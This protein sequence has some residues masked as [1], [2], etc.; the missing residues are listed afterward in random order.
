LLDTLKGVF[1]H[2]GQAIRGGQYTAP[3]TILGFFGAGYL[4]FCSLCLGSIIAL[5][6]TGTLIWLIP[7]IF[8]A[9][10]LGTIGLF[11]SVLRSAEKDPT[12][13]V[14]R[15]MSG[16][17]YI[18][19]RKLLSMGDS[20]SREGLQLP[21]GSEVIEAEDIEAMEDAEGVRQSEDG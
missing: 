19:H 5:A 6:S 18:A 7:V 1:E 4:I 2:L 12:P 14:L 3:K 13:L 21:D 9:A 10:V 11:R 8:L 17:D 16:S 15:E 20:T